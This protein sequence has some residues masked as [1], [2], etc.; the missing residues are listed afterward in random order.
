M[1]AGRSTPRYEALTALYDHRSTNLRNYF[2]EYFL[3]LVRMCHYLVNLLRKDA[4][5]RAVASLLDTDCNAFKD[6]LTE[7][8]SQI[9]NEALFLMAQGIEEHRSFI[10]A[11]S[12]SDEARRIAKAKAI[13]IDACST[14]PYET[15]WRR[16][17]KKGD[18][19]LF[20]DMNDYKAWKSH[21]ASDDRPP[22][23]LILTGGLGSG[24]SVLAAN[25]IEDLGTVAQ[26]SQSLVVYF[27]CEYETVQSTTA[28]VV[29][30]SIARQMLQ[31]VDFTPPRDMAL[32]GF[33]LPSVNDITTLLNQVVSPGQKV[34]CVIDGLYECS[35]NDIEE[36]LDGLSALQCILKLHVCLTYRSEATKNLSLEYSR[37]QGLEVVNLPDNSMDLESFIG[38]ELERCIEIDLL[39]LGDAA[40][41]EE[42]LTTLTSEAQGM[43]LWAELQISALCWATSDKEIRKALKAL[44]PTLAEI[45]ERLLEKAA[46]QSPDGYE[47]QRRIMSHMTV[48]ARSLTKAELGDLL[49]ITRFEMTWSPDQICNNV[50]KLLSS[51]G[52]L[53]SVDEETLAVRFV[54]S[55]AKMFLVERRGKDSTDLVFQE[56]NKELAELVLT[57]INYNVFQM[58]VARIDLPDQIYM[59]Q[60]GLTPTKIIQSTVTSDTVKS[61]S[62]SLLRARTG[63]SKSKSK[64]EPGT[65]LSG[66]SV[67]N[68][69]LIDL[70]CVMSGNQTARS[71]D[72]NDTYKDQH[73]F[74]VYANE[75]WAYHASHN[76]RAAAEIEGQAEKIYTSLLS[77]TI[78]RCLN[79]PEPTLD[80]QKLLPWAEQTAPDILIL[81]LDWLFDEPRVTGV[82]QNWVDNRLRLSPYSLSMQFPTAKGGSR[83]TTQDYYINERVTYF[84]SVA[85]AQGDQVALDVFL[86]RALRANLLTDDVL[87]KCCMMAVWRE[88]RGIFRYFLSG[89]YRETLAKNNN[90]AYLEAQAWI[91]GHGRIES[92]KDYPRLDRYDLITQRLC[93]WIILFGSDY[94]MKEISNE[95]L[96]YNCGSQ[97]R[98]YVR[99]NMYASSALEVIGYGIVNEGRLF[100]VESHL[101]E[102]DKLRFID[103][104]TNVFLTTIDLMDVVNS[105]SEGLPDLERAY[106][107]RL[108]RSAIPKTR[109]RQR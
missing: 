29:I 19:N 20:V 82:T 46:S 99:K 18:T 91:A 106:M 10:K 47:N 98:D 16:I 67:K 100:R 104:A 48:A 102:E 94:F 15:S 63:K 42:I 32:H 95:M 27:F 34:F 13:I 70:S 44:P 11:L 107:R 78:R 93:L 26:L 57:Y 55:S 84:A 14:Y 86:C 40:L 71:F 56:A 64:S 36:I 88:Q 24:K 39:K 4:V 52:S 30:G 101:S 41:V 51:C 37:L 23:S 77:K 97:V 75:Y 2:Y 61:L 8:S 85:A 54:H 33:F 5:S 76:T 45:F 109:W 38:D 72:V 68:T 105:L 21:G 66:S 108:T 50:D 49:G 12:K 35:D 25:L 90:E 89:A 17:R 103:N 80:I 87:S 3:V 65:E 60:A 9:K 74:Y 79:K 53:I 43:F 83:N 59:F 6:Q 73:P 96:D 69:G 92:R 28:R 62:L 31:S 58:E 22:A 81:I 1:T 7:W